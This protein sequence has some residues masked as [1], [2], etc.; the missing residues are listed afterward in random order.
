MPNEP[1]TS[2]RESP[3]L[4]DAEFRTSAVFSVAGTNRIGRY[5]MYAA[6]IIL[7]IG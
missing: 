7:D 1:E 2:E 3:R 5:E 4:Q 6:M